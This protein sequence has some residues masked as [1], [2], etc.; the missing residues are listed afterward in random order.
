MEQ[1]SWLKPA[2]DP[3]DPRLLARQCAGHWA[4]LA[5]HLRPASTAPYHLPSLGPFC[6]SIATA[7]TIADLSAH[8]HHRTQQHTVPPSQTMELFG[9]AMKFDTEQFVERRGGGGEGCS[10]SSEDPRW[11]PGDLAT[12]RHPGPRLGGH[13]ATRLQPSPFGG[14]S[15]AFQDSSTRRA[16]STAAAATHVPSLSSLMAASIS[17]GAR[18]SE[19]RRATA[20][21]SYSSSPSS[22]SPFSSSSSSSSSSSFSSS[23][24]RG[25]SRSPPRSPKRQAPFASS[26]ASQNSVM[27]Q[28]GTMQRK[29]LSQ[30]TA[31]TDA[32]GILFTLPCFARFIS[33]TK[34]ATPG[35]PLG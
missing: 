13:H 25:G 6:A 35:A 31:S 7:R 12:P 1:G 27:S 22:S 26:Q 14:G 10:A 29:S 5:S 23:S 34:R 11:D 2:V 18:R 33:P 24:Q 32:V 3:P 15:Q 4:D 20:D 19:R 8:H 16:P 17:Q 28:S 30:S 9:G 21:G